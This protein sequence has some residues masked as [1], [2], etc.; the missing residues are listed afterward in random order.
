[1]S[2]TAATASVT[3]LG[4]WLL[5]HDLGGVAGEVVA[6]HAGGPRRSVPRLPWDGTEVASRSDDAR[7]PGLP[8]PLRAVAGPRGPLPRAPPLSPRLAPCSWSSPAPPGSR[9]APSPWIGAFIAIGGLALRQ[10]LFEGR[11]SLRTAIGI[12]TA[13]GFPRGSGSRPDAGFPPGYV[14]LSALVPRGRPRR[15][16]H[17]QPARPS[18]GS[19]ELAETAASH[20]DETCVVLPFAFAVSSPPTPGDRRT[21]ARWP[22]SSP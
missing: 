17:R 2:S 1:M 15:D 4:L 9:G 10:S 21:S 11:A 3:V 14:Y 5:L 22:C 12:L 8:R 13:C 18:S 20:S 6:A 16:L 7:A 19:G